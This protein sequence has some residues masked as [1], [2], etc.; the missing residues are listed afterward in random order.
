MSLYL[1]FFEE[2]RKKRE[3]ECVCMYATRNNHAKKSLVCPAA[4]PCLTPTS[5]FYNNDLTALA[6]G[7][8]E[9]QTL[10]EIL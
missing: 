8:F 10:L 2:E 6:P 7:L 1:I 3:R 4:V 5:S 9:S